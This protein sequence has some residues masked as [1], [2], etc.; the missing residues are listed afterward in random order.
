MPGIIQL[1][2]LRQQ[3]CKV[4]QF[5]DCNTQFDSLLLTSW[6]RKHLSRFLFRLFGIAKWGHGPHGPSALLH[7]PEELRIELVPFCSTLLDLKSMSAEPLQRCDGANQPPVMKAHMFRRTYLFLES[8]AQ[9]SRQL[10][11]TQCG[12][13]FG[14]HLP[15]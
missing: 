3:A 12:L 9:I 6:D 15:A 2:T 14:W 10:L 1:L 5:W 11:T 7:V 13:A 8:A 4:L